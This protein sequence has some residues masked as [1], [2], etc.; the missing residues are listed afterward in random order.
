MPDGSMPRRAAAGSVV[1]KSTAAPSPSGDPLEYVMSDETVDRYGDVIVAAGWQLAN[2]RKNPI[3]LFGHRGD[4]VVGNWRDVR[5][6][7][8]RLIGRLELMPA[9][10]ERLQEVHTAIQHG[11]LRA[12]SVGFIALDA[13]PIDGSNTG[14]V[15]YTRSE[16]VECSLASVPANPNAVQIAKQLNLSRET[17]DLIFGKPAAPDHIL[18]RDGENLGKPAANP[19]RTQRPT[20]MS[21]SDLI[22]ASENRLTELRDGLQSHIER[23]GGVEAPD[24]I[25]TMDRFNAD[26]EAEQKRLDGLRRT[27]RSLGMHSDPVAGGGARV[28]AL[29]NPGGEAAARRQIPSFALPKR[30]EPKPADYVLRAAVVGLLAHVTKQPKEIILRERYGEDEAT[31]VMT[32]VLLR[33]ATVPATTTLSGWAAE[34]VQTSV[35]D[36]IDTLMPMSVY[37]KLAALG[38]RFTFGRNGIVSLPGRASTPTIAG[39]FVAEGSPIPVRQAAFTSVTLSPKKM[40]VISTFT[41]EIAEHS[42]P[43][44]ETLIRQIMQEDT[45]I[46]VDSIL[47]DATAASTTRPA[48]LRNGVTVTTAT[49]GGGFD[50]LVGDIKNLVGVLAAANALRAPVWIMNPVQALAISLTQNA[51]GDFPFKMEISQGQL[52]G[53][54]VITSTT[55]T[56]GMVILVD[57]ADFFSATGD[58]P[59]FDVSDQAVLHMED[60]SPAQIGTTGTPSVV[61]APVRSM[62][63]T[64]SIAIRMILP[65]NWAM[66]RDGVIA[67]T[68]SVTW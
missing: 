16:L 27:E 67:W 2:F 26:I 53:Y 12:V 45:A 11:V 5:V 41:R 23:C 4:F 46:S 18:R 64:D 59:R 51:G 66:R 54:P 33:A 49:S 61:A 1:L 44:I 37:P 24:D 35:L 31:R 30:A 43:Q 32:G 14:G 65:L 20:G 42:T 62:F 34:L 10:S 22:Q 48:G 25:T 17:Q 60:T 52:Q 6:E 36:F 56:A 63:Q 39:S 40:G 13:E 19:S 58:E 50:A 21:I 28:P 15:R 38:P 47:L 3:A 8:G 9:V 57:A 55:V 7:G 68:Q 29:L